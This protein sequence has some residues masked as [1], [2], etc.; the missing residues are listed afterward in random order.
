MQHKDN[1]RLGRVIQDVLEDLV[2]NADV[3][4]GVGQVALDKTLDY[5]KKNTT[6][7]VVYA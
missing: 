2:G 3:A 1:L 6:G 4:C 5:I 7:L